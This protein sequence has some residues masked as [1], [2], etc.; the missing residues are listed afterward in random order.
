MYVTIKHQEKRIYGQS[1]LYFKQYW[2]S[3]L[4]SLSPVMHHTWYTWYMYGWTARIMKLLQSCWGLLKVYIQY[5]PPLILYCARW[6]K[7]RMHSWQLLLKYICPWRCTTQQKF[8]FFVYF[9]VYLPLQ[10]VYIYS[11]TCMNKW[12]TL[13]KV[14]HANMSHRTQRSDDTYQI[15]LA[16]AS[17][18]RNSFVLTRVCFVLFH[19][20]PS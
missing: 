17:S 20:L 3:S 16:R 14:I 7:H 4:R 8:F 13:K 11:S 5:H 18:V 10:C 9:S 12:C 6:E 15:H 19:E 1:E 2:V